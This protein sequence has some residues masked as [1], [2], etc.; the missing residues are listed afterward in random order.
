MEY[1]ADK[2]IIERRSKL[3]GAIFR[4][5]KKGNI[6]FV[7]ELQKALDVFEESPADY[8]NEVIQNMKRRKATMLLGVGNG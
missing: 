3:N 4:Q 5:S 7:A 2:I 6:G 1:D 8:A